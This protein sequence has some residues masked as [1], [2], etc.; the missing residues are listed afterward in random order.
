MGTLC[1]HRGSA[2]SLLGWVKGQVCGPSSD[3]G[4]GSQLQEAKG[5]RHCGPG[6][7]YLLSAPGGAHIRNGNRPAWHT[8]VHSR[9]H[10]HQA[11]VGAPGPV[12][13]SRHT[14]LTQDSAPEC[15]HQGS[16]CQLWLEDFL[17]EVTMNPGHRPKFWDKDVQQPGLK[18]ASDTA[19]PR[20]G[21][22]PPRAVG[23]GCG[24][25]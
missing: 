22:Q 21:T 12:P 11:P 13:L 18:S 5:G 7:Q 17:Q 4:A 19:C 15:S 3:F 9:E 16:R 20:P 23:C 10:P 25:C 2:I 6:F 8:R 14:Q 1:V 24:G